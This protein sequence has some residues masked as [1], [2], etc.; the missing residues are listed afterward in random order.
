[1]SSDGWVKGIC[2]ACNS[3]DGL[4]IGDG[5]YLTCAWIECPEPD[6]PH[7]ALNNEGRYRVA[8][9]AAVERPMLTLEDSPLSDCQDEQR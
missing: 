8:V 1:M 5:G 2:P 4:F 7:R 6:A 3:R 9:I